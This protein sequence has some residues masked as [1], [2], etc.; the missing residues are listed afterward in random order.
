MYQS[1][2]AKSVLQAWGRSKLR[3]QD[4]AVGGLKNDNYCPHSV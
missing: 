2:R 1:D 4:E 3:G